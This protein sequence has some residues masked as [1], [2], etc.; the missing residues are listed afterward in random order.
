MAKQT[1]QNSAQNPASDGADGP[2]STS[3]VRWVLGWVATPGL[4]LGGIFTGGLYVG[5]NL[6]T[7]WMTRAVIWLFG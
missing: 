1:A 3:R 7:S 6:D 4:I 5:A 2:S